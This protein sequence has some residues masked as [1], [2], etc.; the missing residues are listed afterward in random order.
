VT[1]RGKNILICGEVRQGK[2]HPVTREL[3]GKG[4]DLGDRGEELSVGVLLLTDF[5]EDPPEVLFRHGADRVY[6]VEHPSCS[7]FNQEIAA[8]VTAALIREIQ[9]EIVLAPATTSGRTVLPGVAALVGTGLT[10]DCTELALEEETGLLLQTRPAIGGNVM[11]TITT[12]DHRPQMATVRP[13]TFPIPPE[14]E[15]SG[16]LIRPPLPREC[17]ESRIIPE[18]VQIGEGEAGNIQDMDVLVSGGKGVRGSEGFELLRELAELLGGGVGASRQAVEAQWI[19]Y[20]H[21]VGLSGKVVSPKLYLAAGISG[22]VQHLAGMQTAGYIVGINK[23]P[24]A[25]IFKVAD[26]ALCGDLHAILPRLMERIRK[27]RG[28]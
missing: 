22:A 21:Q 1:V 28:L 23:D 14:E 17:F 11:A 5:L 24:E 7:Q 9:P 8:K 2:I 25:P 15:R 12:P 16:E 18:G 10:A 13:R 6:L 3:T 26:L 20:P 19:G 27:E 4:R